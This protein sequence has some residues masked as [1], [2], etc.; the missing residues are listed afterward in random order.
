MITSSFLL[1]KKESNIIK[2]S[3]EEELSDTS[4]HDGFLIK[5]K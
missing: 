4:L 3:L 5:Q 1:K 2:S